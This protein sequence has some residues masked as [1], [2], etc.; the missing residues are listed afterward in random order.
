MTHARLGVD[1]RKKDDRRIV[2]DRR[3]QPLFRSILTRDELDDL[4]S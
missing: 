4:L 1:R 2:V 3:R